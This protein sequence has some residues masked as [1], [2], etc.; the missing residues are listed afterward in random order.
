MTK[1]SE[2]KLTAAQHMAYNS[3]IEQYDRTGKKVWRATIQGTGRKVARVTL[4]KLVEYGLI[5]YTDSFQNYVVPIFEPEPDEITPPKSDRMKDHNGVEIKVGDTVRRKDG[6]TYTVISRMSNSFD[7]H[8]G[9]HGYILYPC[10]CEVVNDE[11]VE[12][13]PEP[14]KPVVTYFNGKT[15]VFGI[16]DWTTSD[17]MAFVET[18][19][20]PDNGLWLSL[21]SLTEAPM[22]GCEPPPIKDSNGVEIEP[23][24]IVKGEN[25]WNTDVNLYCVVSVEHGIIPRCYTTSPDTHHKSFYFEYPECWLEVQEIG[26]EEPTCKLRAITKKHRTYWTREFAEL[27]GC[28]LA[29][30]TTLNA[31]GWSLYEIRKFSKEDAIARMTQWFRTNRVGEDVYL[32]PKFAAHVWEVLQS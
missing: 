30:A 15:Q 22:H 6:T 8:D 28:S 13:T 18:L 17:G 9:I 20:E 1:S 25:I 4:N 21:E 16:I 5:E 2:P 11:P 10:Q 7:A 27:F 23:G 26:C 24:M 14:A 19:G 29:T 31:Y 32:K 3:I 12:P